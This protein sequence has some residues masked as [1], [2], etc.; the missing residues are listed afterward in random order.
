MIEASHHPFFVWFFKHYTRIMINSHFRKVFI[1]GDT[2]NSDTSIFI[3]SNHFSWWDGFFINYLNHLLWKKKFHVLMLEEQLESRKFLSKAGAFSIK[4]NQPSSIRTLRY[5][6]NLLKNPDNLLLMY[7]QG[8]IRSQL[9]Y[10]MKFEEGSEFILNGGDSNLKMVIALTD[11][12]SHKKPTLSIYIKDLDSD[13]LKKQK[14]EDHFNF[15]YSECIQKQNQKAD[16]N[17]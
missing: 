6:R 12:F 5:A 3:V 13:V 2:N 17:V 4:K 8:K 11:Y 9:H 1:E 15:F 16:L 10:P 7:P 14:L